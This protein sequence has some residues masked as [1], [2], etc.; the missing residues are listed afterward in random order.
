MTTQTP[1]RALGVVRLSEVTD[2]STSVERQREVIEIK[3]A[4]RGCE[5][6]G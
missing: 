1:R 2:A 5:I 4:Q 3:A 6:I